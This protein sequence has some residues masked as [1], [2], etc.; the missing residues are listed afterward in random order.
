[1]ASSSA[2][3]RSTSTGSGVIPPPTSSGRGASRVQ[4]TT[5]SGVGSPDATPSAK[6]GAGN[7]GAVSVAPRARVERSAAAANDA[8]P[9]M[10]D[11]R[12]SGKASPSNGYSGGVDMAGLWG[13]GLERNKS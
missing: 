6:G 7:F 8:E 13:I 5:P 1:M 3:S 12:D 4:S 11:R 10:N 9:A 2:T